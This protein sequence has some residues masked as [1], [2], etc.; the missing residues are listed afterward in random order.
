MFKQKNGLRKNKI[1]RHATLCDLSSSEDKPK[2]LP[3]ENSNAHNCHPGIT[4][5]AHFLQGQD[6]AGIYS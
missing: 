6:R 2:N 4:C 3:H 5:P 1:N